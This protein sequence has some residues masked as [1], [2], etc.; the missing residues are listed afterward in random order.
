[1]A[2]TRDYY[3]ILG[4]APIASPEEI[5]K[6]YRTLSRKY[7][8]DLN[9]HLKSIAEDRMKELVEA[10]NVLNS[11][12]KR[13][14]YDCQSQFQVRRFKKGQR[15]SP[16]SSEFH[17]PKFKK[18][19]SILDRILSPFVKKDNQ[20]E[21]DV[22][23]P[24]QA[25]MHFTLG[26]TMS[27]QEAF[28]D[29]AKNEFKLSTKFDPEFVEAFYNLGV[30]CYKLGEFEEARISFQKVMQYNKEDQSARKMLSLLRED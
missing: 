18:E 10:F 22:V 9:P 12:D 17:K 24:K 28:Y 13:K 14:E 6:A 8:P 21:A 19:P 2:L 16:I 15:K 26:L 11:P 1:M 25:D 20:A 30:I 29:Q 5:R 27:E 3:K 4:V 7:H 23:D